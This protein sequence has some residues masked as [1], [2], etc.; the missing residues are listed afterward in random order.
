M[1]VYE[2][3]VSVRLAE[4]ERKNESLEDGLV[5]LMRALKLMNGVLGEVYQHN[6]QHHEVINDL[7]RA[8]GLLEELLIGGG[9]ATPDA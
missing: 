9:D 3:P 4:L 7:G 5:H 6:Q 1:A 2:D 8:V